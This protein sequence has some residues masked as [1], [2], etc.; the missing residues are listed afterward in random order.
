MSTD[1]DIN[2][3]LQFYNSPA[4]H[5]LQSLCSRK[6][7]ME[8]CGKST[9]ET[10]HSAFLKWL[11]ENKEFS[12]LP[13]APVITFLRLYSLKSFNQDINAESKILVDKFRTGEIKS[14]CNVTAKTE[15]PTTQKRFVDI[16]LTITLNDGSK[17]RCCIENKI[18]SKEH[19]KQCEAYYQFY[20]SKDDGI[21]TIYIFLSPDKGNITDNPHY[22]NITYQELYDSVLLPLYEY[23]NEHHSDRAIS[24]LREYIETLTSI[25]ED[26]YTPLVMSDEYKNLLKEIYNNHRDLFYAAI[27]AHGTDEEKNLTKK[28]SYT[29]S[30]L[31]GKELSA[32]GYT[33]M[34]KTVIETLLDNGVSETEISNKFKEVDITGFDK[35]VVD[36]ISSM[37]SPSRYQ[38][39]PIGSTTL[40]LN[41][42]WNAAKAN[43]FI[44][45]IKAEFPQMSIR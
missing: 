25:N 33:K 37:G 41:N 44:A 14:I 31:D 8:I 15:V 34:A 30:F 20:Q 23:F 39:K 43:A 26:N 19:D 28:A 6:T 3:V 9:S 21:P 4:L 1:T 24:N 10:A 22:V 16:E 5:K 38:K 13:L 2:D 32:I 18:Y 35:T 11:F 29:V 27:E 45:K 36:D 7:F 42:Q 17:L 12:R 40:Y